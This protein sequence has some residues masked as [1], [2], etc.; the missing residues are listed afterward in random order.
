MSA[1]PLSYEG[2]TALRMLPE[3]AC[4]GPE[5]HVEGARLCIFVSVTPPW[6]TAWAYTEKDFYGFNSN[7]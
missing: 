3:E 1:W 7:S 5:V 4:E 6:Y 2:L